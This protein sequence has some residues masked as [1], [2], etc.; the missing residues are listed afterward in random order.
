M[1][2]MIIVFSIIVLAIV[3]IIIFFLMRKK[4]NVDN[5][6][7]YD[8]SYS[9]PQHNMEMP[10]SSSNNV[11][12]S[13]RRKP[14]GSLKDHFSSFSNHVPATDLHNEVSITPDHV[15]FSAV[16]EKT[17]E[18]GEDT[19][20]DIFMYEDGYRSIVEEYIK[21]APYE[22]LEKPGGAQDV[23]EGAMIT[24]NLSASKIDYEDELTFQWHG[25]YLDFSFLVTIPDGYE[26][27]RIAFTANVY[28][29]GVLLT[30]LIFSIAV[31]SNSATRHINLER[32][33]IKSAFISY[34]SQDRDI[35]A[36]IVYGMKKAR[37][38][39]DIFF[40]VEFLISGDYWDQ[41]LEREII[42]RDLLY[43][44]WSRNAKESEWVEKEWRCAYDAKGSDVIEPIPL[45][46][47]D[48][49]A[50]PIELNN[51]H[52]NDIILYIISQEKIKKTNL[53]KHKQFPCSIINMKTGEEK[54]I[55]V[56]GITIGRNK[57]NKIVLPN[58]FVVS[59]VH[60]RIRCKETGMLILEDYSTNGT[61]LILNGKKE[62]IKKEIRVIEQCPFEIIVGN[63]PFIISYL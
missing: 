61:V 14:I 50:P 40:D 51:K 56:G 2:I 55:P 16:S 9:N 12:Y 13:C 10:N 21:S 39:M 6:P 35:V 18:Q 57:E 8:Y 63:T 34:A 46:P 19:Q 54:P 37:P 7:S 32:H 52:F 33:D 42:S 28:T 26:H 20:I 47:P 17:I 41:V 60:C 5:H 49:C 22:M 23:W 43:L 27:K 3:A 59:R 1:S 24:V 38:D 62:L 29:D 11:C 36:E 31:V 45:E 4:K 53:T 58:D 15:Q 25:K 44:C 30:R 48:L